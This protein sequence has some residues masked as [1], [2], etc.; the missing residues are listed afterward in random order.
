[1]HYSNEC[2]I[3]LHY[4]NYKCTFK[5]QLLWKL[6][7]DDKSLTKLQH[8]SEKTLVEWF[9]QVLVPLR[10]ASCI[11]FQSLYVT[12]AWNWH[13]KI[14]VRQEGVQVCCLF[15]YLFWVLKEIPQK[16]LAICSKKPIS[17]VG[18]TYSK[19][20]FPFCRLENTSKLQ[21]LLP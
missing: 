3:Q 12:T 8:E 13:C 7:F 4:S 16:D 10:L 1:M 5:S 17:I 6:S 19:K 15:Q 18:T 20:Y 11:W 9:W 14:L 2:T 21:S